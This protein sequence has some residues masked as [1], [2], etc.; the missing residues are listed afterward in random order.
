MTTEG[1]TGL[2]SALSELIHGKVVETDSLLEH[3]EEKTRIPQPCVGNAQNPRNAILRG[4]CKAKGPYPLVGLVSHALPRQV[5][6]L[7]SP[8]GKIIQSPRPGGFVACPERVPVSYPGCPNWRALQS[9]S[10]GTVR[11]LGIKILQ[12]CS[13]PLQWGGFDCSTGGLDKPQ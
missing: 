2:K 6:D 7:R 5:R 9:A 1:E 3:S 13:R 4:A 11:W 12:I 8:F 10:L